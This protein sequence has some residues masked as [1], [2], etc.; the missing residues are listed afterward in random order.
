MNPYPF[1]HSIRLVLLTGLL[2][3]PVA[4]QVA[5]TIRMQPAGLSRSLG[6]RVTLSVTANS[7]APLTYQWQRDGL[8]V[9]NATNRLLT[10]TNLTSAVAGTYSVVVSNAAG[11]VTSEAAVLH[12]DTL[13]SLQI[14]SPI[15]RD[16]GSAPSWGDYDNDGFIDLY[17]AGDTEHL[18]YRNGRDGTFAKVG[19]TNALVARSFAPSDVG[20]GYWAD[21]DNDG[22]LDLF[23]PVGA[24][25][26]PERNQLFHGLGNGR[27]ESITTAPVGREIT[28]GWSAA[29]ADFNR[30]G[31]LDLFVANTPWDPNS[32]KTTSNTLY[33]GQA[34]GS[35]IRSRPP[36]LEAFQARNYGCAVGD[37]DGDGFP[38]IAMSVRPFRFVILFNHEGKD[39]DA[40][41][42]SNGGGNLGGIAAGDFDNNGSLDLFG[43][44][45][46]GTANHLFLNDGSGSFED[47][48]DAGPALE[49]A[50]SQSAAWGDY[51]ND[52]YPDLFVP[53]TANW[54]GDWAGDGADDSLWHNNGDGT[55]SRIEAGS[56]GND[57]VSSLGAA[58]GDYD[59]D[60]FLD[61]AVAGFP[62]RLYHNT[63][64]QNAWLLLKLVG[65]KSNR[66]AIGAKVKMTATIRG[67]NLTQF[68]EIGAGACFGQNDPRP[69][70]G[71][72]D[73]TQ[74][75]TVEIEWP[76]GQTQ[77]LSNVAARQILTVT[78]PG[79][80]PRLSV[81][82]DGVLHLDGDPN[83]AYLVESSSQLT[84]WIPRPELGVTTDGTGKAVI[85]I[86]GGA[87]GSL[88]S[89]VFLRAKVP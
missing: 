61:L 18:L 27:F 81:T 50:R 74:A 83:K 79:G 41:S 66:S 68:R 88:P 12:V 67:Q 29:W 75:Q 35:F 62:G 76:S 46:N 48:S 19:K 15:S 20:A 25:G 30:D 10:L 51:D 32:S 85:S 84:E 9:A 26:S 5:P 60:G 24:G 78:E 37:F 14:V 16:N 22:N 31:Y 43:S 47:V 34:D 11:K 2:C 72:G 77:T 1:L 64:N 39:F 86:S 3:L 58:W 45:V 56:V 82:P 13:F 49:P 71:L 23:A 44:W 70:F 40:V 53:R 65:T 59:N 55:F 73:A 69:H 21:Y 87:G 17:C 28:E 38:D 36:G 89:V 52:G 33:L 57:G 8:P 54:T 4:A 7:D 42:L 63:G 6:D 80:A